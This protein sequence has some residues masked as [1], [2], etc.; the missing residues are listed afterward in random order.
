[1][2]FEDF[3][4]DDF[5]EDGIVADFLPFSI[6][7]DILEE[8]D[9]FFEP[10]L[11]DYSDIIA[12]E[13]GNYVGITDEDKD[14][15]E[16][17]IEDRLV[18]C[19]FIVLVNSIVYLVQNYPENNKYRM[20][21]LLMSRVR[22]SY[23]DIVFLLGE[24]L[25]DYLMDEELE[26][27]VYTILSKYLKRFLRR[28]TEKDIYTIEGTLLKFMNE[29]SNVPMTYGDYMYCDFNDRA[30]ILMFRREHKDE[31]DKLYDFE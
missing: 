31:D 21:S 30:L 19:L 22:F 28:H 15:L 7:G 24:E 20:T 11:R 17:D 9:K 8:M 25:G 29:L 10:D 16:T 5:F 6:T 4:D 12:K 14:D 13:V 26:G 1:M 23:E 3:D 27:R 18:D 2:D